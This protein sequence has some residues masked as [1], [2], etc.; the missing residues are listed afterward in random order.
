VVRERLGQLS[1]ENALRVTLTGLLNRTMRK[2][3]TYG[4]GIEHASRLVLRALDLAGVLR[5]REED[6]GVRVE[7]S[8]PL[9]SDERARLVAA[10]MKRDLGVP[11]E[12]LLRELGYAPA[13]GSGVA[14]SI[15]AD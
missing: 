14:G 9:P 2:R 7:W 15:G 3:V 5:T 13:P 11:G 12:T 4:R 6:R 1:S 10:G 8:D